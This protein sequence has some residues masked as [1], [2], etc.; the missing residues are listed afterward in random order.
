MIYFD[1]DQPYF[2]SLYDEQARQA[3]LVWFSNASK[4][5]N[6]FRITQPSK[7][8]Q[9]NKDFVCTYFAT[10]TYFFIAKSQFY[11]SVFFF[12]IRSLASRSF[13]LRSACFLAN[14]NYHK[15]RQS[16]LSTVFSTP[17]T[18][19][20]FRFWILFHILNFIPNSLFH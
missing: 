20:N 1:I 18:F 2:E 14:R 19:A 17:K 9:S 11:I 15:L 3:W 10:L 16:G 12:Q 5:Q 8:T 4:R 6:M 13:L 7:Q